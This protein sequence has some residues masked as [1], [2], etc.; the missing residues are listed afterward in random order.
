M[1]RSAVS[2]NKY[3][4]I[5]LALA[6]ILLFL[7]AGV[8]MQSTSSRQ[9][10]HGQSTQAS[11][12]RAARDFGHPDLL[13]DFYEEYQT[14]VLQPA[15]PTGVSGPGGDGYDDALVP[16]NNKSTA[17]GSAG[18]S[19]WAIGV[20]VGGVFVAVVGGIAVRI[21]SVRNRKQPYRHTNVIVY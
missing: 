11:F 10:N 15:A 13:E 2:N 5:S 14:V 7:V 18:L 12:H 20:I 16:M 19:A 1:V 9:T 17:D 4:F 6:V 8:A 3:L 21:H